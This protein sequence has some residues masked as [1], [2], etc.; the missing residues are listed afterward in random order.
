[1]CLYTK[2]YGYL[3]GAP[4]FLTDEEAATRILEDSTILTRP[5]YIP[6]P[7]LPRLDWTEVSCPTKIEACSTD[8]AS[9]FPFPLHIQI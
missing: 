4:T 5:G 8:G 9:S 1:M 7:Y 3:G 6:G 2:P